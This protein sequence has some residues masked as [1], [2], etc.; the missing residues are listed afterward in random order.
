MLALGERAARAAGTQLL[1]SI[2]PRQ[3]ATLVAAL[4]SII[5]GA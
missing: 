5:D 2:P 4:S 3:R 1:S